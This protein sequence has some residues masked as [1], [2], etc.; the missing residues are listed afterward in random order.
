MESSVWF[1]CTGD[2]LVGSV[3]GGLSLPRQGATKA[4]TFEKTNRS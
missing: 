1:L 2:G 3:P 4:W